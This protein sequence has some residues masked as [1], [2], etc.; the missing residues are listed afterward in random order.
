MARNMMRPNPSRDLVRTGSFP[1]IGDI[2]REF[3]MMPSL[4]GL[5]PETRMRVD[6]EENDQNYIMKAEVPGVD[7]DA[8]T[9]SIDGNTVSIKADVREEKMDQNTS[10]IRSE[11]MFGEEFRSFTLPQEV[12]DAKAQAKM[13]NGLLI[14]TLPKKSGAGAKKLAIQ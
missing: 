11:R 7:K 3:S 4:R 6:V 10:M 12:D 5:E 1:N 2:F 8:I 13:E 14:L 9:V